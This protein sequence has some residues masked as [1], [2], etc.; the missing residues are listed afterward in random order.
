MKRTLRVSPSPGALPGWAQ[1]GNPGVVHELDL[2][3]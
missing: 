1:T 2:T 3:L